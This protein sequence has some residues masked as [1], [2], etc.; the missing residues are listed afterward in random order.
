MKLTKKI[1]VAVLAL[2]LLASCFASAAF[3]TDSEQTYGFGYGLKDFDDI[4]EYYNCDTYV[5]D[6]YEAED[7]L[8]HFDKTSACSTPVAYF[9][10]I[11]QYAQMSRSQLEFY[12]YFREKARVGEFIPCDVT[13]FWLFIYEIINLPDKIPP[14]EPS[15]LICF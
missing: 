11:P 7:A 2:A 5:E 12:F 8:R 1:I 10:Y 4:L 14:K 9:S 6:N 15:I 3:A 13:Y